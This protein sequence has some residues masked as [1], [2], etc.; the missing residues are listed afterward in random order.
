MSRKDTGFNY[1]Q[2]KLHVRPR[3]EKHILMA[4]LR[5]WHKNQ[6]SN[7]RMLF[8]KNNKG[9]IK[10]TA[11][12]LAVRPSHTILLQLYTCV[13]FNR[14]PHPWITNADV[15]IATRGRNMITILPISV[16]AITWQKNI[17]SL[18]LVLEDEV[19]RRDYNHLTWVTESNTCKCLKRGHTG[20]KERKNPALERSRAVVEF[21]WHN[22]IVN[23]ML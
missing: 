20:R 2:E 11:I 5:I 14:L 17:V 3:K 19:I 12:I 23:T 1:L 6:T 9:P 10:K 15:F 4:Y 18:R 16:Y 8:C 22:Y 13:K 21:I 7:G